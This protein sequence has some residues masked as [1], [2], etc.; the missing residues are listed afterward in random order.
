MSLIR[1]D[2]PQDPAVGICIGPYGGPRGGGAVSDVRGTPVC[3][4]PQTLQQ[5]RALVRGV[6]D[7]SGEGWG[8]RG[9][10]SGIRVEG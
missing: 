3:P 6:W 4:T 2:T 5:R 8:V 10:R 7:L 9:E 1:K